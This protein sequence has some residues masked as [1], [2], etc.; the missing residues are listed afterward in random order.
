MVEYILKKKYFCFV[1]FCFCFILFY[2]IFVG[3]QLW[4]GA[5]YKWIGRRVVIV[6]ADINDLGIGLG[7]RVGRPIRR[8]IETTE[9]VF[10]GVGV[11]GCGTFLMRCHEKRR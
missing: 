2:F 3:C 9:N 8:V 1:L 6:A 5:P 10:G 7:F 11:G 4:S